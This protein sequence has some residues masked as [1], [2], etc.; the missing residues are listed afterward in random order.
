MLQNGICNK[1]IASNNININ[2]GLGVFTYYSKQ[3]VQKGGCIR[4][5]YIVY[6]TL[7]CIIKIRNRRNRSQAERV[8]GDPGL[9]SWGRPVT[10]SRAPKP[11]KFFSLICIY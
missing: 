10:E 7:R 5:T 1:G 3:I 6:T 8:P 4:G 11:L 2:K 9:Q